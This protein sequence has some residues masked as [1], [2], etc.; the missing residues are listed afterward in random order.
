VLSL[1]DGE[2][3][4]IGGLIQNTQN[5]TKQKI[6]LLSDIPLI[7][8]LLT[9]HDTT[10][11]KT[12]LI[13]AITPRLVRSVT[14]PQNSLMSFGSGKEDDPSLVR[15]MASFDQEPV[16]EA[17]PKA[18]AGK[19]SPAKPAQKPAPA[20][21]AP[22][23]ATTPPAGEAATSPLTQGAPVTTAPPATITTGVPGLDAAMP[24][25]TTPPPVEILPAPAKPA[26]AQAKRGLVQIAAPSGIGIGQQFYVDIKAGDVLDLAAAPFVLTYDPALVEF[27]S[28]AEG[29]FLK[30][31]GKATV[32]SSSA[33]TAGGT[34]TVKLERAPNSGGVS[35]SGTL[36]SAL[37]KAKSKGAASFGFRSVNFTAADGKPLDM[38]PFSTAVDVR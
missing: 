15:A 16:Y 12:E 18:A 36:V 32:F 19:P 10:R 38:L 31:G 34:V 33:N 22:S 35:G 6:Y 28:A 7:G 27:V 1:K 4:I 26:P 13:L 25:V 37:F 2:T 24:A 23:P 29:V 3:S 30:K 9:N 21:T 14:V 5:N 20:V 17:T 8:P 11:D